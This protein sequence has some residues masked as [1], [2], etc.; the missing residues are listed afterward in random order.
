MELESNGAKIYFDLF[1][2]SNKPNS[3]QV[4]T[5]TEIGRSKLIDSEPSAA[6]Y[7]TDCMNPAAQM[8]SFN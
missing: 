4:Q 1:A 6:A 2:R 8:L 5:F 7:I 3:L